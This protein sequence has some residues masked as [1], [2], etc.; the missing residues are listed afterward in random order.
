[1]LRL[2]GASVTAWIAVV[3]V[4]AGL[5]YVLIGA[6]VRPASA[7]RMRRRRGSSS[8]PTA[9]SNSPSYIAI[10]CTLARR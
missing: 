2:N 8:L 7:Q 4:I 5:S 6:A 10:G 1:M 3:A 9:N